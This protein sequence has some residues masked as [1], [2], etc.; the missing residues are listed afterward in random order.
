[1]K[2][3]ATIHPEDIDITVGPMNYSDYKI[4]LAGRAIVF[5]RQKVAL[6]KVSKHNYYM[7]PGGGLDRDDLQSGLAR[8]ILEELG[9]QICVEKEIGIIEVFFDRWRNK[10]ID[11]CF[12]A[13]LVNG[14]SQKRPTDFESE[15]GH[16]IVWVNNIT[17]AIQFVGDAKPEHTDGKLV[18]ARDLK[19][20]Q[21][22][23]QHLQPKPSI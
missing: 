9:A 20:L 11:H 18:Q 6:I 23:E 3:L 15:E 12:T 2:L 19:F 16:E 5:D 8:E 1:M 14:N 10:Q 17:E 22:Y 7:L 4:R 21:E 13:R